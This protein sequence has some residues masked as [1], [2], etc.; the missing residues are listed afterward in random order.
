MG[1]NRTPE[2]RKKAHERLAK[3]QLKKFGRV[4]PAHK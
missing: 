4:I 3:N 1:H 2:E